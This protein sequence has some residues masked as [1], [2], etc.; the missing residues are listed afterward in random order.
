[1]FLEKNVVG[2][3]QTV[4][5][6]SELSSLRLLSS[7]KAIWHCFMIIKKRTKNNRPQQ[8]GIVGFLFFIFS[9]I[10]GNGEI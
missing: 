10:N 6:E 4:P 7:E 8:F 9:I 2:L 5:S 1:M 3:S